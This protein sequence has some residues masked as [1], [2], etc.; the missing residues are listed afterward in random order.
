MPAT[1]TVPDLREISNL[2]DMRADFLHGGPYGSG[3]I[4]DTYC[5]SFDQA[6]LAPVRYIL[7]RINTSVF[8]T[9]VQ[10]ME[11]IARVTRHSLERLLEAKNPEARRRTLTCIPAVDGKP[12]ATDAAGNYWRVMMRSKPTTRHSRRPGHSGVSRNS[13]P[14][15]EVGD[16][17]KRSPI[18]T[19]HPSGLRR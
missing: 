10:L 19:T 12:Y 5:A 11:N 2:F 18:S 4:N 14:A 9:P 8:K 15:S 13:P 1:A 16:S 6:G 3:H 7:Q 17:M